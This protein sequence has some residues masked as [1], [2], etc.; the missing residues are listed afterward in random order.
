MSVLFAVLLKDYIYIWT[1]LVVK[2]TVT[3]T[4]I[5]LAGVSERKMFKCPKLTFPRG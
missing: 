5:W 1:I 4:K 2:L 3:K